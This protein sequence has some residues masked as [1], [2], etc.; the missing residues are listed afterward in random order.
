M[1]CKNIHVENFRNIDIAD[2]SFSPGV[3]ILLGDNA[4]G[5]TNMIEAVYMTALGRSFRPAS[6]ADMIKFGSEFAYVS[7]IYSDSMRDMEI[8]LRL[9]S[10]RRQKR[11]EQNKVKI[12]KMSDMVGSF[13]V[14]IF[15]PEHLSIIKEGPSLRRSFLDVAISQIKPLYIKSLQ[16][17]NTI[18]KERNSLIKKAQDS[19]DSKRTFDSTV[20]IWS[21]QLAVEAAILTEYRIK[22]LSL[23]NEYVKVCFSDMT[24]DREIPSMD[25]ISSSGLS[26]DE[27]LDRKKCTERY[28]ELYSTRHDRE[29]GAG[30]TLWGVH[31][32]DVDI[33]LNGKEAR[34][35][36][37]QGQ[38]RS[39]ALSMKL[40]EGEIIK[41]TCGGDY[42]VFL[43]DDVLSELD[44]KRREYLTSS[45]KDK[46]VIMTCCEQYGSFFD[47]ARVYEV[48]DGVF[49]EMN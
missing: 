5:K 41:N 17:Y 42:P 19:P 26:I 1:I 18:L 48:K 2:V 40:A 33:R 35:Y 45:I 30:A 34:F 44:M 24:S 25:Y 32:D 38:Q 11:I 37:S 16:R 28:I 9:F 39:L 27:C 20:D 15:C 6:D 8:S 4:Q 12:N 36:C 21:E 3:N 22:Y 14:V 29:I 10:G 13:K 46:Q 23:A 43:L 7:N 47:N 31:K 49:T